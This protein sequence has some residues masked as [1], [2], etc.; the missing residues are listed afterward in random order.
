MAITFILSILSLFVIGTQAQDDFTVTSP[1]AGDT[2]TLSSSA[3]DGAIVPIKWTVAE[4]LA[5]RPAIISL[6]QGNN[7]SSLTLIEQ[8]NCAYLP[9][10]FPIYT[11]AT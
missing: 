3:L 1:K 9:T 11:T 4:S 8:V 10:P 7:L 5:E 6:V 2:V